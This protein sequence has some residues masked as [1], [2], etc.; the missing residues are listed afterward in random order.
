MRNLSILVGALALTSAAALAQSSVQIPG[1]PQITAYGT[2]INFFRNVTD[3]W[4][5]I[6]DSS[7]FTAQGVLSPILINQV[8]FQF[9]APAA[10]PT[11][12]AVT[13]PQ[14][15]VYLQ[16]AAVDW[17]V[18]GPTFAS[19]RSV[20]FPTTPNFTGP[21]TTTVT[22]IQGD[23][24]V[25]IPLT[26]PFAYDPGTG[27][28]LLVEIEI[29][30]I[31]VPATANNLFTTHNGTGTLPPGNFCNCYRNTTSATATSGSFTA[32]VPI[33]KFDYGPVPGAAT[34]Q[35]LGAGCI[36]HYASMYELFPLPANWDLNNSALTFLPAGG[37]YLAVR[38]GAFMPVGSV[39]ATPT[40]LVLGDD[41]ELT[42]T[43]TVGSFLGPTGP[44]PAITIVSNGVISELPAHPASVAGGGAPTNGT[45]LNAAPT[46]FY[47]LA[48]W[49]PSAATGGGNVWYEESATVTTIT[50]E[51][52]PNWVTTPPAPGVNTFQ[53]QL[54]PSGQVT[55][56]WNSAGITSFG[57]NGGTLVGY[58]PGGTNLD[59]GSRDI[60]AIG[61]GSVYIE[62]A[63]ISGMTLTAS[64]RPV[65]GNTWTLNVSNIEASSLIGLDIFG[66]SDPGIDNLFFIGMPGCGLR[67]T[68]DV[69]SAW[70]VTGPTHTYGFPVPSGQPSL[71][72]FNLFTTS[73]TLQG[74]PQNAFGWMTANG[75]KGTL[76]P[77]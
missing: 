19:N 7:L 66:V 59:P 63:D 70:L 2:S 9:G 47:N 27:V 29:P 14:I 65:F 26:T 54:Y 33:M 13:Y 4:Q 72:G 42:Q 56:A 18:Q 55:I 67:S 11:S 57:N 10:Q 36:V 41:A 53:F 30:Q 8:S 76:G 17:T 16:P 5:C 45:F 23:Y 1:T 44:W 31:P 38:T 22:S 49:D 15:D 21:V 75:M 46:A 3:K 43:F 77:I 62:A 28:D 73:A 52:V 40:A 39:Q 74:I 20:A 51:N 25:T 12:A 34:V 24:F 58:S 68:L 69:T 48:D 61:A 32:F 6:Y 71:T 37:A 35:S 50:W 64:N 60:S